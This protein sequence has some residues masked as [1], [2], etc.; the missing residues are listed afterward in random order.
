MLAADGVIVAVRK[1]I[2]SGEGWW[3]ELG[4]PGSLERVVDELGTDKGLVSEF[5]DPTAA[6]PQHFF[7]DSGTHSGSLVLSGLSWSLLGTQLR[8]LGLPWVS[9]VSLGL[10]GGSLETLLDSLGFLREL[11]WAALLGCLAQRCNLVTESKQSC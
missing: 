5:Q 6:A 2:K 7:Q 8:Y 1:R 9:W 4:P 11:S 3:N 10:S